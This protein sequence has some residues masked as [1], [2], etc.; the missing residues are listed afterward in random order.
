MTSPRD[1]FALLLA[2]PNPIEVD[3]AQELLASAGI[4]SVLHGDERLN[5]DSIAGSW[6]VSKRP[7][8]LVPK[9]A[10]ERARAVLKEAWDKSALT[11]EIALSSP[12]EEATPRETGEA[13]SDGERS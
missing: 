6:R 4:P 7:D 8:L 12:S 11:D 9:S 1:E 13:S 2:A 3:M 10:L 5:L